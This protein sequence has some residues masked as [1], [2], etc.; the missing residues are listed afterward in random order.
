MEADE[1]KTELDRLGEA[2]ADVRQALT[3]HTSSTVELIFTMGQIIKM[4]ISIDDTCI[5][6]DR[7]ADALK[8][9]AP[10]V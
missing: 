8:Q 2:I 3:E 6:L 4:A 5:S 10:Y 7:S 1:T 9:G